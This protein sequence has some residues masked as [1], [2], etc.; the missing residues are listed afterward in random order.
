MLSIA[1]LSGIPVVVQSAE[2]VGKSPQAQQ[3]APNVQA[4]DKQMVRS[5]EYMNKMQ[6]QMATIRQTQDPQER[7]KLLQEH[8]ETMQNNMQLMEEI[9]GPYGGI[10][11]CMQGPTI[12]PGKVKGWQHMGDQY[13]KLTAE[14]MQQRQ[15]MMDRFVPMQQM[16]MQQLMQH[17]R[18]MWDK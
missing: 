5:Q 8:W 2:S 14:Q 1:V 9:W 15:Y 10:V 17:Q 7:Q 3:L 11:C 12:G 6:E 18:Y 4:F 16:M 13:F